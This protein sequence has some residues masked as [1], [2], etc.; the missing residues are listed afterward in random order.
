MVGVVRLMMTRRVV[1]V[2][3]MVR[4]SLVRWWSKHLCRC[5]ELPTVK[6]S[7]RVRTLI[8][9]NLFQQS[10]TCMSRLWM[11]IHRQHGVLRS[12]PM[13]SA[14]SPD[15][16]FFYAR[17]GLKLKD[18]YE[19]LRKLGSGVCSSTWLISDSKAD[20]LR[21]IDMGENI[22]QPRSFR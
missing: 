12:I 5:C 13:G 20:I 17:P 2:V 14:P 4:Y 3:R 10:V 6:R 18:R 16:D 15:P 7:G 21:H 1:R 19:V 9:P 22:L 8:L 11:S